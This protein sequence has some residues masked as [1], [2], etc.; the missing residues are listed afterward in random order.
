[1]DNW[2]SQIPPGP[3]LARYPACSL[4]ANIGTIGP[5]F[6]S[7]QHC[8]I[9]RPMGKFPLFSLKITS[10]L[11]MPKMAIFRLFKNDP[12]NHQ[13][14][15]FLLQNEIFVSFPY[16]HVKNRPQKTRFFKNFSQTPFQLKKTRFFRFQKIEDAETRHRH[17]KYLKC[18]FIFEICPPLP[19]YFQNPHVKTSHVHEPGISINVKKPKNKL[20]FDENSTFHGMLD[21]KSTKSRFPRKR[22][23]NIVFSVIFLQNRPKQ[24]IFSPFLAIFR[25]N[26]LN[27]SKIH[28]SAIMYQET[29]KTSSK[30]GQN[31][32][33]IGQNSQKTLKLYQ[34][35]YV[36]FEKNF[37]VKNFSPFGVFREFPPIIFVKTCS[38]T[39]LQNQS[40]SNPQKFFKN[41]KTP[42]T[43]Q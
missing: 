4:H 16:N 8:F 40:E 27:L 2:L 3:S 31:Q 13:I 30:T 37:I 23:K 41:P 43:Q 34:I 28:F 20:F 15:R 6:F 25:P 7:T 17:Q 42:K 29:S 22:Y 24:A 14:T 18:Y 38:V 21:C 39:S 9:V 33:K 26:L 1:M 11:E 5:H 32:P 12:Q 36:I 35:G 10:F 19:A